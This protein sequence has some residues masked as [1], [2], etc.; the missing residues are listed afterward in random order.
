MYDNP[1]KLIEKRVVDVLFVLIKLFSLQVLRLRRYTS[2]Y[3]FK[4]SDFAA[5]GTG[6]PKISGGVPH[7][8]FFFSLL[9]LCSMIFRTV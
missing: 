9:I 8:P 6:S 1:L 5:T 2:E 3:R 7:K 4:I